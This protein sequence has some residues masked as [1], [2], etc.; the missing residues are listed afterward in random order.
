ML[1]ISKSESV[2]M[3]YDIKYLLCMGK[4]TNFLPDNNAKSYGQ[5]NVN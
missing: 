2:D 5:N 1:S 3:Y 4:T